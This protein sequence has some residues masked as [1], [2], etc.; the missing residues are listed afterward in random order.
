MIDTLRES[1][2]MLR[3]FE[4][5]QPLAGLLMA[6]VALV[7]AR[8]DVA[9]GVVCGT[10]LMAFS[11]RAIKGGVELIVPRA[12]TRSRRTGKRWAW[13]ARFVGRYALLALAAY[14]MLAYL[15][16]HPLGLLLGAASP[17]VAVAIEAVRFLRATSR[18]GQS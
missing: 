6:V 16:A 12:E 8:L 17:V 1:D 14:V 7:F 11:Y 13:A 3:R 18:P 5:N 9:F 4:R 15:H 10:A 2:P